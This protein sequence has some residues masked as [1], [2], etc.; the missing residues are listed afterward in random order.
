MKRLLKR[1]YLRWLDEDIAAYM[2][3][4]RSREDLRRTTKDTYCD[5]AQRLGEWIKASFIKPYSDREL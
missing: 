4:V 3:D 1:L 2:A 5:H